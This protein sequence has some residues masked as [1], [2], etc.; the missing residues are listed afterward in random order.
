MLQNKNEDQIY[1]QD[2]SPT[3][4]SQGINV[5]NKLKS[6]T[7]NKILEFYK[8]DFINSDIAKGISAIDSSYVPDFGYQDILE[9][10]K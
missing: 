7:R 10:G 4:T 5:D 2:E 3:I 8:I 9:F 1:D 6:K